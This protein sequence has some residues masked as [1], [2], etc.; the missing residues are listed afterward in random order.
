MDNTL[1][2]WYVGQYK[3]ANIV[4]TIAQMNKPS[5]ATPV[6]GGAMTGT[7][8]TANSGGEAR[9]VGFDYNSTI[10]GETLTFIAVNYTG[11]KFAGWQVDGEILEGYGISAKIPYEL[12]KDK[13][14]T[15]VF[16]PIDSQNSNGQ[17]DNNQTTDIV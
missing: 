13:V 9:M 5:Y 1:N 17:T 11:Y 14:V 12:V 4:F 7:V 8:V 3:A 15:A 2:F 16:E 10:D 6:T